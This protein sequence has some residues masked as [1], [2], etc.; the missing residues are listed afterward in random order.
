LRAPIIILSGPPG[1]GKTT[2]APFVAGEFDLSVHLP[3]DDF[4][5]FIRTGYIA[6][7][8]AEATPQ[9]DVVIDALAH[10]ASR[11]ALGGYTVVL[12]GIVGPWYLDV[13]VDVARAS[14]V[15]LHYVVLRPPA[16]VAMARATGRNP[17]ELTDPVPIA[18]M[19]AVLQDLGPYEAHVIDSGTVDASA[20]AR[21]VLAGLRAGLFELVA[22]GRD[23]ARAAVDE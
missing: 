22:P 10:A 5:H 6:P 18:G 2:V 12:D 13:F 9:N 21:R 8:L 19:Y 7:F 17:S 16:E 23:E 14:G 20:A 15:G 4:F 11:Y 1:A 3:M